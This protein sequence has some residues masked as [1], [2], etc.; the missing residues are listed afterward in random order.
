MQIL[1][2]VL[3]LQ[4]IQLYTPVKIRLLSETEIKQTAEQTKPEQ[5]HVVSSMYEALQILQDD[6]KMGL[7]SLHT[8]ALESC[9]FAL[10]DSHYKAYIVL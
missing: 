7:M 5:L 6:G 1:K 9:T 8:M 4:S 2:T 3:M 10:L